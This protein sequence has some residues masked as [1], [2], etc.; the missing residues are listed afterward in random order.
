MEENIMGSP[1]FSCFATPCV[2]AR[3]EIFEDQSLHRREVDM[4]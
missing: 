4:H 1:Y 2:G 3:A